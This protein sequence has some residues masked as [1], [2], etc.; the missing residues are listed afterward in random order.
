[1]LYIPK[2]ALS[3]PPG[4]MY[5]MY[6]YI[7]KCSILSIFSHDIVVIA[8]WYFRKKGSLSQLMDHLHLRQ[9]SLMIDQSTIQK[10]VQ[11]VILIIIGA[12]LMQYC[13][14]MTFH[15]AEIGRILLI[16]LLSTVPTFSH[17]NSADIFI[18]WDG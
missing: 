8:K 5:I 13:R 15:V 16:H 18:K 14:C 11:C 10:T 4:I 1:M 3:Y 6:N 7:Y 2:V 17:H 9:R 12:E